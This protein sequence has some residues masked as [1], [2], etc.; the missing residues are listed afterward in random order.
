MNWGMTGFVL[1]KNSM[2]EN[3][4]YNLFFSRVKANYRK[5]ETKKINRLQA[6]SSKVLRPATLIKYSAQYL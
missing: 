2:A 5:G 3:T 4:K 1:R 6:G